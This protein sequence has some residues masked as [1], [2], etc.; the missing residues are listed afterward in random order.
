[1]FSYTKE[2]KLACGCSAHPHYD[3]TYIAKEL[4]PGE[5]CDDKENTPVV[6]YDDKT[7]TCICRS[8]PCWN[9]NGLRHSCEDPNFPILYYSEVEENM[10][11]GVKNVKQQCSCIAK[12][13]G[14]SK[15]D[16]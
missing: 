6:D 5:F 10:D 15:S 11:G 8:H 3:S 4:C 7:N 16:L 13:E 2:G 1:M 9:I 12:F 14:P